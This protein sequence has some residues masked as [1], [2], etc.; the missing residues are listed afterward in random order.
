M[1]CAGLVLDYPPKGCS[2]LGI[3]HGGKEH[4]VVDL[5]MWQFQDLWTVELGKGRENHGILSENRGTEYKVN[6]D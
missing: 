2:I 4:R 3:K 6:S 1:F 5:L